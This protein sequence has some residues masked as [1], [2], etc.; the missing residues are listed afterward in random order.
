MPLSLE[1]FKLLNPKVSSFDLGTGGVPD[2]AWHEVCDL[3]AQVSQECRSYAR[4][5]YAEDANYRQPL[6]DAVTIRLFIEDSKNKRPMWRSPFM[7]QR[8]VELALF[9]VS[10]RVNLTR[11]QKATEI[12]ARHWKR[13]HEKTLRIA[14]NSIDE[15]DY[16]LRVALRE[17]NIDNQSAITD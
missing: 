12:G 3:L 16:E 7:W 15:L 9:I 13:D 10:K 6:V 2:V 5:S 4:Y 11:R 1:H 8:I 17:W 14:A